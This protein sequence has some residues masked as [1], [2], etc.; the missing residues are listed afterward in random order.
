[1]RTRDKILLLL[2]TVTL[3]LGALVFLQSRYDEGTVIQFR[4]LLFNHPMRNL[5]DA[6]ASNPMYVWYGGLSLFA[7]I[8]IAIVFKSVSNAELRAFK[9]RLVQ[10]EVAKAEVETAL[11]DSL[12][13]EKHARSV[14]EAAVQDLDASSRRIIT[15]EDRLSETEA[16]LR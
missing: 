11:Q 5:A 8:T 12:W 6:L 10:A 2:F 13:K 14:K 4:W 9:E 15:L 3:A 16:V 1:M 7:M